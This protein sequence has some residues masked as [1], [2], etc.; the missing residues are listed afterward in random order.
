[1][2]IAGARA[3]A[4]WVLTRTGGAPADTTAADDS[5]APE[6]GGKPADTSASTTNPYAARDE[7]FL[8]TVT[9]MVAALA[10]VASV[11]VAGSQLSSIG[12]LAL[13]EDRGRLAAA[14]ISVTVAVALVI[15][16]IGLLTWVQMPD[17]TNVGRLVKAHEKTAGG[18]STLLTRT[19][20]SDPTL[21]RGATD[22]GGLLDRWNASATAY[23]LARA[24]VHEAALAVTRAE[25]EAA[26]ARA[27]TTLADALKRQEAWEAQYGYYHRGVWATSQLNS[28]IR[29]KRKS[30][31]VSVVV[32]L[33]A[34]VA[35]LSFVV[36]AW[37][38][39]PPTDE[40]DSADALPPTPVAAVL[41]LT[42]DDDVWQSRLGESCAG[43]ARTTEGIPVIAVA[44]S[45]A[46][47]D[48]V[49]VPTPECPE[50]RQVVIAADEGTVTRA[51]DAL[52]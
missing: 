20:T 30:Q 46:G 19:V 33:A 9:W 44:E 41:V 12:A 48:V 47:V 13:E 7:K 22:L 49:T 14:A 32:P 24:Q 43:T 50:P 38:S 21:H 10:G 36:F 8:K 40:P 5:A 26:K 45:D 3:L 27:E 1:M 15:L 42:D 52:D 4:Q 2:V 11:M 51:E 39:N 29:T 25:T 35:A 17:Y 6:A 31:L 23:E 34:A 28:H 37:A 18:R 16:A